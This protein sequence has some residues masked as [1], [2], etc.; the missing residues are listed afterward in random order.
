MKRF[1]LKRVHEEVNTQGRLVMLVERF[2]N[3]RCI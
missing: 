3:V 2:V 1:K